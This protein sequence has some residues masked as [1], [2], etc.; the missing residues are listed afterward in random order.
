MAVSETGQLAAAAISGFGIWQIASMF[1]NAAP[2]LSE[3]R[4]AA[5]DDAKKQQ[6]LNDAAMMTA[7]IGLLAGGIASYASK[8][9]LPIL[10]IGAVWG[11]LVTVHYRVLKG[12]SV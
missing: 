1:Q 5:P 9:M 11:I 8:S 7:A 3:L 12:V 6:D 10:I 2:K 4:T